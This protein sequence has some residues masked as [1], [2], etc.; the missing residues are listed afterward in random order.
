V[1]SL[2]ITTPTAGFVMHL[3]EETSPVCKVSLI[4]TSN[5]VYEWMKSYFVGKAKENLRYIM[6]ETLLVTTSFGLLHLII[7]PVPLDSVMSPPDALTNKHPRPRTSLT[8]LPASHHSGP[9]RIPA[10][11]THAPGSL[12]LNSRGPGSLKSSRFLFLANTT[13]TRQQTRLPSK[14]LISNNLS[15]REHPGSLL[16][17]PSR[18][19]WVGPEGTTQEKTK[20]R[21]NKK[22]KTKSQQT[23]IFFLL[24]PPPNKV[25]PSLSSSEFPFFFSLNN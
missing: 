2:T 13:P 7:V 18:G 20:R 11:R 22:T 8:S 3:Q 19:G 16:F 5:F 10:A 25:I 23:K 12:D 15:E 21:S 14:L 4:S 1:K 6:R 24:P 17:V 9:R